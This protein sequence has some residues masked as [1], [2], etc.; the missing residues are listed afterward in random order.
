MSLFQIAFVP[1]CIAT[2]IWFL[3]RVLR[4][5]L[6]RQQGVLWVVIWTA[7]A[8]LIAIPSAASFLA[9]ALG[10]GRGSDLVFYVAILSG[11]SACVY[12]YNRYRRLE[13]MLTELA[14]QHA[15]EHARPGP[16]PDSQN[17]P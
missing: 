15:L 8:I 1:L 13:I 6:P 10:I 4:G 11:L 7:A 5:N 12:F 17:T 3:V 14:R 16:G 9:H 2:A